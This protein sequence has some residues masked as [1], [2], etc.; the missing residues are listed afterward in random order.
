MGDTPECISRRAAGRTVPS[1][2]PGWIFESWP[3]NFTVAAVKGYVPTTVS[4][5]ANAVLEAEAAG[6]H[7]RAF[8]G[9]WSFSDAVRASG[10]GNP[11][12]TPPPGVM[13]DTKELASSLQGNLS[14]LLADGV[15]RDFLFHVEAGITCDELNVLLDHEPVRQK[16]EAGGGSGQTL[17]GL[18]STATHSA[19]SR[20]GPMTDAVRAIHLVGAG[21]LEHW[22]ERDV[23]ITSPAKLRAAYPCLRGETIH[24]NTLLFDAV[25]VSAGCMGVIYSVLI[26]T[27]PQ[28]GILQHRATLTWEELMAAD[29]ALAGVIDG[30]FM[31]GRVGTTN[32]HDGTP[33]TAAA[34]FTPNDFA[35]IVIN[36]Y[37]YDAQDATLSAP[38]RA[39]AGQHAC[40]VTNHVPIAVPSSEVVNS[41]AGGG[42][43]EALG[44][45]IGTAARDTMGS[46][47]LDFDIRFLNLQSA[48]SGVTDVSERAIRLVDFLADHYD[49]RTI[50][51]VIDYVLQNILPIADRSDVASQMSEVVSW[52]Q[53]IRSFCVEAAFS[54]P[55]AVLFIPK[56]L[57]LVARYASPKTPA[58]TPKQQCFVGGYVALRV[59][60]K[61]TEA[62]LGMQRWSPTC[63]VEYLGLAG[64]HRIDDFV[65]E[66]EKLALFSGGILHW[67]LQNE[68]MTAGD[69]RRVYTADRVDTFRRARGILSDRGRATFDNTF[70]QRF[71]LSALDGLVFADSAGDRVDVWDA[72]PLFG[73][74]LVERQAARLDGLGLRNAYTDRSVRVSAVRIESDKDVAGAPAFE[75]L[76]SVPFYVDAGQISFID[77]R[78]AGTSSGPITGTVE[79]DCDDAIEPRLRIDLAT[80]V[81]A[82]GGRA[83]LQIAP[84]PLAF[85]GVPIADSKGVNLVFTNVGS[86]EAGIS[87]ALVQEAP[88]GQFAFP[89]HT[90][91][92]PPGQSDTLYISCTPTAMGAASAV[93]AV[94]MH[95][96]TDAG[97]AYQQTYEV[98]LTAVGQVPR[99]LFASGPLDP[100]RRFPT[101]QRE[102]QVLE[103]GTGAPDAEL[104]ATFWIR[105][106]GNLNLSVGLFPENVAF[107][108][109][110]A[111]TILP[112]VIPPGGELAVPSAYR[113]SA[114]PGATT[115]SQVRLVTNDPARLT[116]SLSGRGRAS[117]AHLSV[118]AEFEQAV[119]LV[120]PG[121][122]QTAVFQSDGTTAITVSKLLPRQGGN[123]DVVAS[124][125]IP[126][127]LP[128]GTA[129][130]LTITAVQAGIEDYLALYDGGS[131]EI[132]NSRIKLRSQ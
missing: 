87:A 14:S 45:G 24:Y 130:A 50:S 99:L 89:D 94:Q 80:T 34:P 127:S 60:G 76:S 36:P 79:V 15:S 108:I 88:A 66:L 13:I 6:H 37:P 12:S 96:A 30:S 69:V 82:L 106:V 27:V 111:A 33:M 11:S 123:F 120:H 119:V 51:G 59:V 91:R 28:I 100:A 43:L 56:L 63:C 110:G 23:G 126:A 85:G 104:A 90:L 39:R 95:S 78:Y 10:G 68:A 118:P 124:P 92:V 65:T 71:G 132:P 8:G 47:V 46:N 4:E 61:Q 54:V 114:V 17:A 42:S 121:A 26:G 62:L 19:E 73:A 32:V 125:P 48:L 55:D 117:G 113:T 97:P 67:G 31:A 103:F 40:F 105:N 72:R 83:E 29:P 3:R 58:G 102:L 49:Q 22:I 5:L 129:L 116:A 112:A 74:G 128:P 98:Q 1:L 7:V 64:T 93:L 21:G 9:K 131:V 101:R 25:L 57:D 122:T 70:T 84:S 81:R 75:V 109:P 16:L 52:G 18:L 2:P 107:T 20:V 38:A 35:Q 115:T 44:D 41:P 86:H 53:S 77:A